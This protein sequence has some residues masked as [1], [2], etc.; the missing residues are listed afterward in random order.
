[1][2]SIQANFTNQTRSLY[3]R[4]FVGWTEQMGE[5]LRRGDW[6]GLDV[7]NLIE[8]VE[9]LGRSDRAAAG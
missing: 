4:D 7:E 1:M 2:V 9:A 8:E 6:A 3:E 5:A